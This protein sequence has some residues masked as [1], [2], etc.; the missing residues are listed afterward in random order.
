MERIR[1]KFAQE[2]E[3]LTIRLAVFSFLLFFPSTKYLRIMT[4]NITSVL[5]M[6]KQEIPH[7]PMSPKLTIETWHICIKDLSYLYAAHTPDK[8]NAIAGLNIMH[9]GCQTQALAS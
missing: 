5:Y 4:D 2:L 3:L 6:N 1:K 9:H 7:S 8:H